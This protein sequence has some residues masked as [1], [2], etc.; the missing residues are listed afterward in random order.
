MKTPRF[1]VLAALGLL[2]ALAGCQQLDLT[3]EGDPQRTVT[4]TVTVG[5]S[6]LFPPETE[7]LVRVT[8]RPQNDLVSVGADANVVARNRDLGIERVL[9]EQRIKAPGVNSFP[10]RV[11]FQAT[12]AQLRRGVNIDVRISY[13]GRLQYRTINA[14][15]LTLSGLRFPQEV[16]VQRV[17]R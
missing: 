17:A 16:A 9:G 13:D 5:E 1:F 7:V 8:D 14:H 12:D 6:T 3:P 15:A 11:D 10:F 4:G 2:A